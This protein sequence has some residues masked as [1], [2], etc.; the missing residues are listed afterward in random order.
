MVSLRANTGP[1]PPSPSAEE[2]GEGRKRGGRL[3]PDLAF[4]AHRPYKFG[5]LIFHINGENSGLLP[6]G[7]TL[8]SSRPLAGHVFVRR[9]LVIGV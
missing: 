1:I 2:G 8:L 9:C 5:A 6:P 7:A 3:I 4:T